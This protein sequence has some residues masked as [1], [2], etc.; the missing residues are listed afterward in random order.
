VLIRRRGLQEDGGEHGNYHWALQMLGLA[1]G[2]ASD[3]EAAVAK[4]D[5]KEVSIQV[6][7]SGQSCHSVRNAHTGPHEKEKTLFGHLH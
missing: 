3:V 4:F 2:E 1:L 6:R 5:L 7:G